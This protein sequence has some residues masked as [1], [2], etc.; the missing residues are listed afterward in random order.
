MSFPAQALLVFSLLCALWKLRRFFVKSD[1]HN[2]PGPRSS[3]IFIGNI[4]QLLD[5]NGWDFHNLLAVEF[6]RVVRIFG[7]FYEPHLYIFDPKAMHHVILK[8]QHIFEESRSLIASMHV[9]LGPG[10]LA[11]I[12]DRHKKQRKML[13]PVFSTAHMR[14]MVPLF[15]N[16]AKKLENA[17]KLKVAEAPKEIDVLHWISRAALEMIGQS[18]LGYSF[19]PLVEGIKPHPYSDAIKHFVPTSGSLAVPREYLYPALYK[20]GSPR[21]RRFVVNLLPSKRVHKLRDIVDVMNQTSVEIVE[22]KKKALE[23]DGS[24]FDTQDQEGKDIMSILMRANSQAAE[25]EKLSDEEVIGQVS[26]FAFA[27]TDTTSNAISRILYLL[28][29]NPK[30]QEELRTEI[31]EATNTKGDSILLYDEL[32][33][34][35]FLEAVCRETL[36]LYPPVSTV[37]RVALQDASV[38]LSTP[39]KGIDGREMHS[40]MIPKNTKV[41]I[42]ILNAN[43]DPAL[44]GPDAHEW[45][46]ERW[47]SPLPQAVTDAKVPGI[48]GNLMT[49]LGGGRSCI[50]FK[51]SQLEMKVVLCALIPKFRFSASKEIRWQMSGIVTPTVEGSLVPQLPLNVELV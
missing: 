15:T 40:I 46:P 21:F 16:V 18:G 37:S 7:S 45:K 42:S 31:T 48:Y 14:D 9:H 47:L 27:G 50:G 38:P 17:I 8:D 39:V 44:W 10:L 22:A 30:V 33:A 49:F 23:K 12:G 51:F 3:S 41:F 35:P 19:D 20:L 6:G 11:T 2:I 28:A 25:G 5:F 26:T 24:A 34:L 29:T 32:V 43:R 36:R 4:G 13:N 1:V